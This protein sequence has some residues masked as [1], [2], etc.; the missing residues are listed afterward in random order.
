MRA[1][2]FRPEGAALA[3]ARVATVP[4]RVLKLRWLSGSTI[5]MTDGGGSHEMSGTRFVAG[6]SITVLLVVAAAGFVVALTRP[7]AN[8]VPGRLVF[9]LA[10]GATGLLA[11][12]LVGL[13]VGMAVQAV[14]RGDVSPARD[15][16]LAPWVF[17][18]V[19]SGFGVLGLA[20]AV[21][22]VRHVLDRW[23]SLIVQPPRSPSWTATFAGAAGLVPFGAAMGYWGLWGVGSNGPQGMDLPA[24]RTVLVVTG[25]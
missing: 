25:S 13:P 7:W 14:A 24:Q 2:R 6:N 17:G 16:G 8:R 11:P 9:V 5:G 22:V 18:T 21:L 10:A 15:T 20:M 4:Y 1:T 12:I 3:A 19:Y 23:G